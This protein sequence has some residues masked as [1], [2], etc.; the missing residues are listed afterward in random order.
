MSGNTLGLDIGSNSIG[1]ALLNLD[2][3]PSI[4]DA[5]VRVFQEGVNRDTKGAE[6]SKNETRR[7]ARGA[8]RNRFRRN[9]RKDKLLRLMKRC[10]LFPNG[11]TVNGDIFLADPYTLRARGL[12]KKLSLHEFGRV[13]YHLN[14][15]RGFLSNR[16]SSK[17]KDDGV[18]IK[19]ATELQQRMDAQGARTLGEY[20]AGLDTLQERIR[21][22]YT[23]RSMYQKEFDLLWE[24]QT[25]FYPAILTTELRQKIADATIF[26]QRPLKPTDELI[27]DCVLEPGQKRCPKGD[28]FA[29]RFRI[30]QDINNLLV[31]E[32]DGKERKLT[33]TEREIALK[34]LTASKE[35]GFDSLRKKMGLL[36]TQTFNLEE[37]S[38]DKKNAKMQGDFF[39]A[40]MGK[41][42]GKKVWE[43]MDTATQNEINDLLMSD[44]FTDEQVVQMLKQQHNFSDEQA[45]AA[46]EIGFPRGYMSYSRLAIQKLLPHMER[47]L[48]TDEAVKAA[49]NHI[50]SAQD[51]GQTVD[52]LPLPKDLRNPIV[53]KALIEARKVI[54]AIIR[55]YRKP[56]KI[57]VEM[58]RDVKGSAKERE[59][60]RFKIAENERE[61]KQAEHEL[62]HNIGITRP[63]RDDIIKYKLWQECGRECPYTG[64]TISQQAL[65]G[66][67]P[68]FQIEHIIPYSRSLDDSY[69]N[70]TLCY[71][72]ENRRKGDKMPSEFYQ[73][74]E[75]YEHILQRIRRLPYPKRQKFSQK[76]A[77]LDEFIQRQLNDTRYITRE[78]LAYLKQ[79]GCIVTGSRGKVTSE[80]RHQWG[81]NSILDS[82]LPGLKN[83]E[84]HR[85]HA[86]DAVVTALTSQKHLHELAVT[87]YAV[88]HDGF[89]TPWEGFRDAVSEAINKIQV[90]HRVTRKVSGPLHEETSYGPTGLKDDKGQDIFVYRKSLEVLTCPMVE[91]IVDPV[92]RE[93]VKARLLNF[94]IDP[95]KKAAISKDVWKEPLYMKSNNGAK[96]P[97]K[98][99]RIRDVFNNMIPVKDTSRK[100]YRYVASGNNH[101]IEIFEYTDA[102]GNVKRDGKVIS[103]FEA[104]RRSRQGKPVVCRDY[105]DGKQFVCSLA[106]N[107]MYMLE[108]EEGRHTLHRVQKIIQDGRIVLRPTTFAG[109]LS[110]TDNSPLIQRKNFNTI[111]G[112]KVTVDPIGRIFP[113]K[114]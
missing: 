19:S 77:S 21:D 74:T 84:D 16:K 11:E 49:Y 65:F 30:L 108:V 23:F 33:D 58:A 109:K 54:N 78:I 106:K 59:E 7:M 10:S 102:K 66:E 82:D 105:D 48:R 80:L 94:G 55:T 57:V 75:Q 47:G 18:V 2:G 24:K 63:T 12:D 53:N 90:S 50:H 89:P 27:G 113:A 32:P 72:D 67:H 20:F 36:E 104:V 100:P 25:S 97:I 114:D 87:K 103:M 62:I 56:E 83:R 61:N 1:W 5:G 37:G 69:M 110:D 9:Y 34:N 22:N 4:I 46:I 45:Q 73:G 13:L 14:Q 39:A 107:E 79:L 29:R 35:V 17:G 6:I 8:R 93:I 3:N 70:K 71:V 64:R 28:W 86:I 98:K 43:A 31:C 96:V 85:H 15:R 92:V 51:N 91:K 88:H 101:H 26:Y 81:L 99:V 112:Y 60:L 44:D 68:E 38:F 40:T 42:Q 52:V 95:E 41:I 111:R 76:E